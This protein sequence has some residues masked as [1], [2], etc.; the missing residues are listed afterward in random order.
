ME[1]VVL[2][3]VFSETGE[4]IE[5]ELISHLKCMVENLIAESLKHILSLHRFVLIDSEILSF[6]LLLALIILRLKLCIALLHDRRISIVVGH[7]QRHHLAELPISRVIRAMVITNLVS[8]RETLDALIYRQEHTEISHAISY[9]SDVS[10]SIRKPGTNLQQMGLRG[11]EDRDRTPRL[12]TVVVEI[13]VVIRTVIMETESLSQF[14]D[15]DMSTV[16]NSIDREV[17]D[18]HVLL[19]RRREELL[20]APYTCIVIGMVSNIILRVCLMEIEFLLW[21]PQTIFLREAQEILV[22]EE[23]LCIVRIIVAETALVTCDE[24]FVVRNT[25]SQPVVAT[26]ILKIPGLLVINE[27]DAESFSGSVLLNHRA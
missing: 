19:H 12:M 4:E 27:A 24:I 3:R 5:R 10:D 16:R 25:A 17:I 14:R 6:E 15:I 2:H 11:T 9:I 22:G 13:R 26:G 7:C 18:V 1:H 23:V 8:L 20:Q 21:I